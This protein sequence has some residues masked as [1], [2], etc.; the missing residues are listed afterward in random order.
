MAAYLG[1][2]FVDAA[3]VIRFNDDGTFND[4]L[5]NELLS[6]RLADMGKRGYPRILRCKKR[7]ERLLLFPEEDL[8]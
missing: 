2:E 7:T 1:F 6:A 5:T 8:T 3:E 4:A